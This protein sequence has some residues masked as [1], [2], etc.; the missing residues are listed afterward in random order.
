MHNISLVPNKR[1]SA[2]FERYDC[3][4]RIYDFFKT[5]KYVWVRSLLVSIVVSI[6]MPLFTFSIVASTE[7]TEVPSF[8]NVDPELMS[9]MTAE[10]QE[11]YL[12]KNVKMKKLSGFDKFIYPSW[13]RRRWSFTAPLVCLNFAQSN[14]VI[15]RSIT[16]ASR[17]N[18]L[19]L[20]RNFRF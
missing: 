3:L 7:T 6:L 4:R 10:E 5:I 1:P 12:I 2:Q 11:A 17:L 9:K 15:Q 20:K 8:E 19:F 13:S 18:N 16:V 14:R